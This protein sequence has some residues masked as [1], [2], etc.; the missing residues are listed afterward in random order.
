[1]KK[2]VGIIAFI[3][4][5]TPCVVLA[6]TYDELKSR[7]AEFFSSDFVAETCFDEVPSFSSIYEEAYHRALPEKES[8]LEA[9]GDNCENH[10][11]LEVKTKFYDMLE[12]IATRVTEIA[13]PNVS[14]NR[15]ALDLS[16]FPNV[17]TVDL[18]NTQIML[19]GVGSSVE[20]LLL[21]GYNGWFIDLHSARNLKHLAVDD[22]VILDIV[23]MKNKIL[24]STGV[25]SFNHD[26]G[27]GYAKAYKFDNQYILEGE[28]LS[29]GTTLGSIKS[30]FNMQVENG[31]MSIY[32]DSQERNLSDTDYV[33][34]GTQLIF[35]LG[36]VQEKYIVFILGDVTGSGDVTVSDVAKTYQ[37]YKKRKLMDSLYIK[38]ANVAGSDDTVDI[39]DVAKLYQYAKHKIDHLD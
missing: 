19:C 28:A 17:R 20:T 12:E 8:C 32:K 38:A 4:V 6:D 16:F 37:H 30:Q 10:Y 23:S 31:A 9:G 11:L 33:G 24:S 18:T 26:N 36:N 25:I 7:Y 14:M 29:L 15:E 5:C 35:Q 2:L 34:T 3:I 21:T 13:C 1:M 39:A 27:Q 22:G